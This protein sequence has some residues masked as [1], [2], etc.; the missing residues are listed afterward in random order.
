M[1]VLP[2]SLLPRTHPPAFVRRHLYAIPRIFLSRRFV[3]FFPVSIVFIS[4][5]TH[6]HYSPSLTF[7]SFLFRLG[8]VPPFD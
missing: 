8:L 1:L 3:F 6:S 2:M 7:V 5:S 4:L